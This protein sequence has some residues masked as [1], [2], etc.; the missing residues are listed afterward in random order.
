MPGHTVG[1]IGGPNKIHV[2]DLLPGGLPGPVGGFR[3]PVFKINARIID[4][5]IDMAQA[6][7]NFCHH[8]GDRVRIGQICLS[9]NMTCAG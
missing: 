1:H 3:Q 4:Q 7:N 9:H 6:S 2:D 8:I 5:N